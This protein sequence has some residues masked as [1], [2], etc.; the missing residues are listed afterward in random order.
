[1]VDLPED[2]EP[3][4]II[5]LDRTDITKRVGADRPQRQSFCRC[6]PDYRDGMLHARGHRC[7]SLVPETHWVRPDGAIVL[8]EAGVP[9][10]RPYCEWYGE[11]LRVKGSKGL[12][13]DGLPLRG[14]E[15][16]ALE[17]R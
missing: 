11:Y 1:M 3:F 13:T 15:C 14:D 10:L 9:I 7:T 4:D 8:D 16:K 5:E 6:D 2:R 12:D 17:G